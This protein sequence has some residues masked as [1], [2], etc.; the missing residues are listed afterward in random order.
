M[1]EEEWDEQD[2]GPSK[3]QIKKSSLSYKSSLTK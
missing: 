1:V 3:T 2:E